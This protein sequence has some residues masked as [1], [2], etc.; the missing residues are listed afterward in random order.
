MDEG[1]IIEE[2][3]NYKNEASKE[4]VNETKFQDT[5]HLTEYKESDDIIK[6][7]ASCSDKDEEIDNKKMDWTQ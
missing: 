4:V 1:W 3:D 6:I 5:F 2:G 7:G